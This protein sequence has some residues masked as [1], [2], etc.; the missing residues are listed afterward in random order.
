[1]VAP[2]S[3]GAGRFLNNAACNIMNETRNSTAK[4]GKPLSLVV[5]PQKPTDSMDATVPV[6]RHPLTG[7][8]Q[9][10][11]ARGEIRGVPAPNNDALR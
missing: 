10:S 7:P 1:M 5:T 6:N 11:P 8:S 2:R 3:S 4:S 9:N